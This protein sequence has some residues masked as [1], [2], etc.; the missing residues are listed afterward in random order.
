MRRACPCRPR[1]THIVARPQVHSRA[2][3]ICDGVRD[4]SRR[5]APKGSPAAKLATAAQL[6]AAAHATARHRVE[7]GEASLNYPGQDALGVISPITVPA[8]GAAPGVSGPQATHNPQVRPWEAPASAP[9]RGDAIDSAGLGSG[10]LGCLGLVAASPDDPTPAGAA[11]PAV[12][13]PHD[14]TPCGVISAEGIRLLAEA[15]GF[16]VFAVPHDDDAG[17]LARAE[18]CLPDAPQASAGRTARGDGTGREHSSIFDEAS[19]RTRCRPALGP[20]RSHRSWGWSSPATR[21]CTCCAAT[22]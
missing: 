2:L 19:L 21:R 14:A 9:L 7:D 4:A 17:G 20:A 5:A 8:T 15:G 3:C 1:G 18:P 12:D 22:P 13:R 16:G 10:A 6:A 11:P